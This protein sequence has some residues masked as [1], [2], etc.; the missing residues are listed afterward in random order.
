M[1]HNVVIVVLCVCLVTQLCSTLLRPHGL[2]PTR[3]LCAW[4][5]PGKNTGV[6]CHVL[7]GKLPDPGTELESCISGIDRRVLYH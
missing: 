2:Q 6:G 1:S 3:L 7:S 5:F 4:D